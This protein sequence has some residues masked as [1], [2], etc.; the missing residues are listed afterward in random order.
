M[1]KVK[2]NGAEY[3]ATID[4]LM[5]DP[6]WDGRESKAITLSGEFEQV[7]RMFSDGSVWS[8]L[9]DQGEYDN[10]AFSLRG[11]LTVHTDGTCTVKMGKLTDLEDAYVLLYGGDGK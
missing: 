4:G 2:I 1:T 3:E 8:I 11:D 6:D 7:N 5:Y 10:S 9:D